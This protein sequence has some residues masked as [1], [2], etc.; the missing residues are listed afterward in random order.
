M[1]DYIITTTTWA[2]FTFMLIFTGEMVLKL[3]ALGIR[4]YVN[5]TFNCFDAFIVVMS[6]VDYF[7]P[8][9]TP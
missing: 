7:T 1:P 5:D 4:A 3:I 8:G 9:N 6:Y 2:N